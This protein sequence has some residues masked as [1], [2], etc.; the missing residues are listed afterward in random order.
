VA[1]LFEEMYATL[2]TNAVEPVEA[3]MLFEKEWGLALHLL[4][5]TPDLKLLGRALEKAAQRLK[6]IPVKR[7]LADTPVVLL[8]GEIF[9]R[10]D[11]ISRQYLVE[12]LARR[13]FASRVSTVME[14]IYYTDWCVKEGVAKGE[15]TAKDRLAL[16]LR[17]RVMKKREKLFRGILS[18]SKLCGGRLEDVDHIMKHTGHLINPALAGEAILT[19][20]AVL[21]EIVDHCCGAIAIGPFG[22]MP[23]RLAE[24]ILT[25][26]MNIEGKTN[27]GSKNPHLFEL[28]DKINDLPFLAIE[29]DGNRF[30]QIITAKLEAFLLQAGRLHEELRNGAKS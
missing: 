8:A 23:N 19:V 1:S 4:E 27:A 30:P 28:I 7:E 26:E 18:E 11:G 25:R 2:I 17:S 5:K 10:H 20:G 13:G 14:W 24:S 12:E 21:H 29:S 3:K 22:C 15:V 16:L 9:V 6:A